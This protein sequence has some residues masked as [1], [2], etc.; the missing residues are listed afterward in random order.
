MSVSKV[1][2]AK[3]TLIDLTSDTVNEE[4]LEEGITAHNSAGRIITGTGLPG[5]VR[6]DAEQTLTDD[7]KA[8]ARTNIGAIAAADITEMTAVEMTLLWNSTAAI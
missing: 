3:N 1:V 4:T 7:Q 2:Y 5:R 6:Y 8:Q